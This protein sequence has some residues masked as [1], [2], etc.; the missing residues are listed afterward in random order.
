MTPLPLPPDIRARRINAVNGL[1]MHVLEAGEAD[2]PLLLL[3]HGF[4][5]LAWSWRHIMPAL[6]EAGFWVIAPDQRGYGRTTGA[7]TDFGA[8]LAP[9]RPLA[10]A[11]DALAL[12]Q[13]LGRRECQLAGHDFGSIVAAFAALARPDVFRRVALM[14]APFAGPPAPGAP[15]PPDINAALHEIGRDHYQWYYSTGRAGPEMRDPPCGLAPFLRAY[16]HMKGGAWHENTPAPLADWSA[17]QLARLPAY[18]VMPL[19]AT[20]AEAVAPALGAPPD[21][22]LLET[23]LAV[24]AAEYARTGFQGGLNWYAARTSRRFE[25]DLGLFS[26]RRIEAPACFIA[27]A[28][29]WGIEQSPGT[30]ARMPAACADWRGAHLLAGAGHWVQQE[31]PAEVGG[32]LRDFFRGSGPKLA[33]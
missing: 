9:Y 13:A 14:S 32:L 28:R 2:R 16:F 10:L 15:P 21:P 6:A 27:G 17:G 30:L 33:R 26:G 23:D 24:Y 19:G 5:E 7:D 18:Y 20:M 25:D 1:D 8:D 31:A 22:W 12:V 3:L 29:D 11:R 4:P